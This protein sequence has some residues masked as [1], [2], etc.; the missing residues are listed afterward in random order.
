MAES[1]FFIRGRNRGNE[2]KL[3][4]KTTTSLVGK[5]PTKEKRI[6]I[7]VEM[8]L[9]NAKLAGT[10]DWIAEAFEF[11][12]KSHDTVTP[13]KTLLGFDIEFSAE[14]LFE[15]SVLA[16]KCSLKNF[17]IAENGDA[18]A[19]DV[20]LGFMIYTPYSDKLWRWCGQMSGEE[21]W[22]KFVQVE[23]PEEDDDNLT[24]VGESVSE[25]DEPDDDDDDS[26]DAA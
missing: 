9:T 12:S 7:K 17:V 4:I 6:K 8:P 21:Q 14:Q 23:I 19:P 15:K 16:S 26:G 18:E 11:V 25:E 2:R 5:A 3:T 13:E 20:Y 10:P 22:G 1:Q 24:L